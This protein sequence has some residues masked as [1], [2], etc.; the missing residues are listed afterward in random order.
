MTYHPSIYASHYFLIFPS[1]F[2]SFPSL[3]SPPSLSLCQHLVPSLVPCFKD[4][5]LLRQKAI[6]SLDIMASGVTQGMQSQKKKNP[7]KPDQMATLTLFLS[8]LSLFPE[9]LSILTSSLRTRTN[10]EMSK[11]KR[12]RKEVWKSG[13]ERKRNEWHSR[14]IEKGRTKH[15]RQKES[16]NCNPITGLVKRQSDH[17]NFREVMW[18]LS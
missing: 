8:Y 1:H 14:L 2:P 18:G 10:T 9:S 7:A 4:T 12:E 16:L 11:N 3:Y 13:S 5:G 6:L 17:I 15:E